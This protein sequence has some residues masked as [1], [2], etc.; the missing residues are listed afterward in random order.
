MFMLYS[1]EFFIL[2][3]FFILIIYSYIIFYSYKKTE[4]IIFLILETG[5]LWVDNERKTFSTSLPPFSSQIT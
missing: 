5:T 2:I 1:Y 3:K 4:H